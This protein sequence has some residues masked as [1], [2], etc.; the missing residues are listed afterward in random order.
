MTSALGR[1][2]RRLGPRYLALYVLFDVVSALAI[3]AATV[4]LFELYGDSGESSFLRVLMVAVLC[5]LVGLVYAF[6][7]VRRHARPLV[8]WLRGDRDEKGALDAWVAAVD[9]PRRLVI[10]SGWVPFLIVAFPT[11][12]YFTLELDL[13]WYSV[14]IIFAGA[15]LAIAY[16]AVL[17]FFG[18]EMFLRPVLEDIAGHLPEEFSGRAAGVPLR[19]K[20]LAALP[21]INVITGVVVSGLST[22]GAASLEDLGLDV[23]VALVVAFTI[24]FELTVLVTRSVLSGVNDLLEATERVKRGDLDA[25]VP[26]TSGDEVG[27]LAGSFNEMVRGLSEREALREAFGSYVDPEVARRVIDE[28]ELLE[29]QEKEVTVGFVDVRDFT[30]FAERSS[31]RD[32]VAFLNEF[33]DL[34][35]PIVAKHGGHANKFLGDGVLVVFGAPEPLSDHADRAVAAAFEV[36][37][38]VGRRFGGRFRIGIGLNSG[39]VVVGSVGGG[40]RL[41][42][43][44]IGDPVN[45]AARVEAATRD[46]GDTIL[47]TEATR[48]LIHDEKDLDL[49]PRGEVELKGK[50]RPVP[51][52]AVSTELDERSRDPRRLKA[53][54]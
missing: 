20:L 11:S 12:I 40:G 46:T 31:P 22:D 48:G 19:L 17:H 3:C 24:S 53:S 8:D 49:R 28:G 35:V 34:V 33:F 9:L 42:F 54:A 26:L 52:Y 1:L 30:P 50:T 21:V 6:T 14:F 2:Y 43:T 27:R 29:G 44:V 47:L 4:G 5:V 13:P 41:E 38:E 32:T 7:K 51:I 37:G 16:A 15:L 45:V 36:A 39:K 10:E 23:I 25:R 18:A